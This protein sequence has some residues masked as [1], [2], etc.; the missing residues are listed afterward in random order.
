MTNQLQIPDR[1]RGRPI[2]NGYPTPYFVCWFR[3]G[4]LVP[5]TVE[6]AV[7]S[8]PT[9][10]HSRLV[11]CRKHNRC[12]ICGQTLG[13]FK[14]FVFGPASALARASYEPPSHRDCARYAVQVC[15]Y[16]INPNFKHATERGHQLRPGERVL[17]EVQPHNP[18][19]AVLWITRRYGVEAR[20]PSRGIFV[21]VP[22]EPEHVELW[23][24]GRKATYKEVAG[25]MQA[26]I[27]VNKMLDKG[28]VRELAWRV[29]Q[30]LKFAGEP[31]AIV[32]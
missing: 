10:D 8:F 7:P 22:G 9:T 25:A 19:L 23:A 1:L 30:L 32:A 15:P 29:Q 4:K 27:E 24:H 13:A 12:W 17:P 11:V 16:L 21:F 31:D 2:W 18:G 6:G 5:E 28:N 3:D 14:A 26:A 20:D